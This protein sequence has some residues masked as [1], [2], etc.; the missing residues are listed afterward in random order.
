MIRILWDADLILEAL[1]NRQEFTDDIRELLD[2][3]HPL[4]EMYITDVGWQKIYT[5]AR[6]LKNTKIA[7]IVLFWLKGKIAVC[8]VDQ[9]IIHKARSLPLRDFESAVELSCARFCELDA[10]VTHRPEDFAGFTNKLWVW[11][12]KDLCLRVNLENQLQGTK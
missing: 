2:T 3:A 11:S 4:I 5:Y 6:C 10:I 1:I 12:I 8:Q 9:Q 7:E